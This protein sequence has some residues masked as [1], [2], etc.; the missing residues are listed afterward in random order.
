MSRI[1]LENMD[2]F[3]YHGHYEEEKYAGNRFS[4]DLNLW[5]DT[6]KVEQTDNIEDALNYQEAYAI[7]S[8]IIKNTKSNL[9]ENIAGNIL[10]ALFQ[11]FPQ[12]EKAQIKISKTNPPMGGKIGCVGVEI[13]KMR[14]F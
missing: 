11:K 3:A 12:L 7:V 10:N 5:T 1:F 14:N 4:V 6:S 9:V 13:E 8:D 2:F